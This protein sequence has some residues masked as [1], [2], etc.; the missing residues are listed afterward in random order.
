MF[1]IIQQDISYFDNIGE[2]YLLRY[3]NSRVGT[4]NDFIVCDIV[5]NDIDYVPDEPLVRASSDTFCNTFGTRLLDICKS[6]DLRIVNGRLYHDCMIG[7]YTYIS[8]LGSS[9]I[10]YLLTKYCNFSKI[11]SFKV[12]DFNEWSDHSPLSFNQHCNT[13]KRVR[14]YEVENCVYFKWVE[15]ISDLYLFQG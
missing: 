9:V 15:I 11:S 2:I 6:T 7:N 12:H 13:V 10:D 1:D 5:N 3:W 4:K 8:R 14:R